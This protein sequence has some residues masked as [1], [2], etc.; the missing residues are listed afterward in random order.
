MV[1]PQKPDWIE[2]ELPR[3]IKNRILLARVIKYLRKWREWK[4]FDLSLP[5][6]LAA[7]FALLFIASAFFGQRC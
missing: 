2:S 4:Y 6:V 1:R 7:A 5:F 3:K